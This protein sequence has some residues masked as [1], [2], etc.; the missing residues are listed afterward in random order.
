M[1]QTINGYMLKALETACN[2]LDNNAKSAISSFVISRKHPNG[3]FMGKSKLSDSYYSVFGYLLSYILELN[4]DLE[5][6]KAHISSLQNN[7]TDFVHAIS[8]IKSDF[9]LELIN[10]KDKDNHNKTFQSLKSASFLKGF[11]VKQILK[12]NYTLLK[13]I[14]SFRAKDNTY[15]HLS[16]NANTG[17]IYA[18][19]LY[20]SLFQELGVSSNRF[21]D[22]QSALKKTDKE[23]EISNGTMNASNI[24]AAHLLFFETQGQTSICILRALK[25]LEHQN[26][27]FVANTAVTIPD[28]L[29]TATALLALKYTK[30]DGIKNNNKILNFINLHWDHTGGFFGSAFDLI[31]DIEYTFYAL[32]CIGLLMNE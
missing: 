1:I 6:E 2:N 24:A 12:R 7:D 21:I 8:I 5:H 18:N 16:K 10:Y 27:G 14:D 31:S 11:K 19:Y 26:G 9:L 28:L 30:T 3:G 15:N 29:S 17:S 4:L 13:I 32:L 25:S 23:K 20:Y 22:I